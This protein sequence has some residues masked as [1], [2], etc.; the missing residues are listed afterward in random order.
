MR[1]DT[2]RPAAASPQH[3]HATPP[4]RP[5]PEYAELTDDEFTALYRDT[6]GQG[7]APAE[8]FAAE[9]LRRFPGLQFAHRQYKDSFRRDM[10]E[11]TATE[12][13][14]GTWNVMKVVPVEPS[15]QTQRLA[16]AFA[17]LVRAT[18]YDDDTSLRARPT[19][20]LDEILERAQI[21]RDTW[22]GYI[23]RGQVGGRIGHDWHTGEPVWDR[24]VV[25]YWMRRRRTPA[26]SR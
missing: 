2:T 14:A 17:A 18:A 15:E 5:L 13:A 9:L 19:I 24:D 23:S 6:L 26:R 7:E 21:K 10:D 22:H 20:T 8:Y 1:F 25:E 4:E 16:E 3:Y 12:K 11:T